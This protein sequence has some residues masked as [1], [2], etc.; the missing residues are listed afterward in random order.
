MGYICQEWPCP[1]AENNLRIP[2]HISDACHMEGQKV[3]NS[4]IQ[5]PEQAAEDFIKFLASIHIIC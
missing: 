4:S 2:H 5:G 1:V 3:K